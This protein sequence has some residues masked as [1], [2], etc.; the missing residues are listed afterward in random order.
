[1]LDDNVV[2]ISTTVDESIL[3]AF[4]WISAFWLSFLC[5]DSSTTAALC[6]PP[7]SV[8]RESSSRY[9]EYRYLFVDALQHFY[10]TSPDAENLIVQALQATGRSG[11]TSAP[12]IGHSL[13]IPL[14]QLLFHSIGRDSRFGEA[15]ENALKLHKE[16]GPRPPLTKHRR[17]LVNKLPLK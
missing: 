3:E 1:V 9:P 12:P 14:L 17:L 5:L 8:L 6:A 16:T 10:Q 11:A 4:G 2:A 15:F 13:D 7:S